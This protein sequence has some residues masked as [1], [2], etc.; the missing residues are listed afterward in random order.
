VNQHLVNYIDAKLNSAAN[1]VCKFMPVD[2]TV[3]S[4]YEAM[5]ECSAL[6]TPDMIVAFRQAVKYLDPQA[7]FKQ[8]NFTLGDGRI[9]RIQAR[10]NPTKKWPAFLIPTGN[11]TINPDG[12]FA[13][14][15][16]TPIRVATEWESLTY[17]W[18]R[19][20]SPE[21]QLDVATLAYLMPWI[22]ECLADFDL[23][24]LD[25]S[26]SRVERKAIEKELAT[27]MH[28][29]NVTFFPRMSKALSETVR[30]GKVLL[31]Q[32]RMIDAAY[33]EKL[34][35]LV[36]PL[37][38]VERTPTLLE[39]WLKEHLAEAMDEWKNDRA[40]RVSRQLAATRMKDAKRFDRLNPKGK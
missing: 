25:V 8:F 2:I 19:L 12:K 11:L 32:Y 33:S 20:R 4:A 16:E 3:D 18:E 31:S 30:S 1:F 24:G 36:Q 14:L 13:A 23:F 22:R 9:A 17:M 38:T 5:L 21:L 10:F 15:L 35:A 39:P 6:N 40:L 28:D 34:L 37:I 29:T 27:V 7:N 26:V